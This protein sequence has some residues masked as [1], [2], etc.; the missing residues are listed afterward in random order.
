MKH[1]LQIHNT[2]CN[3]RT[4]FRTFLQW[5]MREDANSSP[6]TVLRTSL[7]RPGQGGG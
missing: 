2:D 7:P 6:F 3:K 4:I 5:E 1:F